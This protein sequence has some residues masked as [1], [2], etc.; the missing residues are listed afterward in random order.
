MTLDGNDGTVT[1]SG[2]A[3]ITLH[4]EHLGQN[5]ES[6]IYPAGSGTR[7]CTVKSGQYSLNLE[8]ASDLLNNGGPFVKD[9]LVFGGWYDNAAGTGSKVKEDTKFSGDK[10]LYAKWVCPQGKYMY[11]GSCKDCPNGS[12][13]MGPGAVSDSECLHAF[14]YN[15]GVWTWPYSVAP[16]E[17]KNIK[18]YP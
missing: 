3:T 7:L 6:C 14:G 5:Q 18:N 13:T 2:V 16:G 4:V 8:A 11:D 12:T 9:G 1:D 15:D 17:L 10:T